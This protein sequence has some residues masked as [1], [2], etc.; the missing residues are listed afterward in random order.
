[1]VLF[2]LIFVAF[3][4]LLDFYITRRLTKRKSNIRKSYVAYSIIFHTAFLCMILLARFFNDPLSV[5]NFTPMAIMWF[6]WIYFV[7]LTARSI[8]VLF[9]LLASMVKAWHRSIELAGFCV[10]GMV[11]IIMVYGA[12]IGRSELRV[13][14]VQIKINDLP[15]SFNGYRIAHFSDVHLGN[16]PKH[17]KLV[18]SMVDSINSQSVDMVA[19]TGDLINISSYELNEHYMKVLSSIQSTDGVHSVWGNHDYGIYVFD[20]L[21]LSPR[22]TQNQLRRKQKDMGWTLLEN[23]SRW[24]KRGNDS[25]ALVG[26]TFPSSSHF[27]RMQDIPFEISN[28]AKAMEGVDDSCFSVLLSH[29]PVLFDSTSSVLRYPDLTLSGHVHAMQ[30]KFKMGDCSISP[31]GLIYNYFSGLYHRDDKYLYINDGLGFVFYP[32]RIGTRPELTIYTLISTAPQ[33]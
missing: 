19:F 17:S 31:A 16:L 24:I 5:G 28:L 3:S 23:E 11:V 9:L 14:N 15:G 27:G 2:L 7:S 13:E 29:S 4:I 1:M 12:T 30:M 32:M 33:N 18:S 21:A 26:V 8:I 6:T 10:A 25:V 20:T 22:T